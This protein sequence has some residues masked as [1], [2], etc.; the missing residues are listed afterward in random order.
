MSPQSPT[1][2]PRTGPEAPA[3]DP[4]PGSRRAPD[5]VPEITVV[6]PVYNEAGSVAG[7]LEPLLRRAR[8]E[9]WAVLV[10]DDGS[11]DGS[12][13]VLEE[14]ERTHGPVLRVLTHLRNR[15]YGAALKTGI[16]AV[17]GPFVATMDSDG[18]HSVGELGK[19]LDARHGHSLVIGQRTRALHSP[20]WRMPGKWVLGWM[21]NLFTRTRI[22]DL[23]SGLRLF[24]TADVRRYLHL[25]PDGFSF[26]TTS[27]M[28]MLSRGYAVT[29]VPIEVAPRAGRSTVSLRT[30]FETVLLILRLVML[31]TPL[32]LFLPLGAASFLF[33]VAWSI[34]YLVARQGL[35][36]TALLFILNGVLIVLFGLLADQIAELRKERFE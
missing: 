27:T 32:R 22:P 15:G 21:A 11:R 19:L 6:L 13:E 8:R 30:G 35:T 29:H 5:Q 3:M 31:L 25:C 28:V 14:L 4:S 26:S 1:P 33:G 18:Q 2:S 36:V 17:E 7:V 10:V 9:G 16:R 23:N 20:L 12:A 34:P 24:R